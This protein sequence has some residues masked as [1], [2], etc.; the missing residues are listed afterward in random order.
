MKRFFIVM[1]LLAGGSAHAST[2]EQ[3]GFQV[4]RQICSSCHSLNYVTYSDLT[5]LGIS[6]PDIKSYASQHQVP[7]GLD[8]DGD[9]KTRPA[10]PSDHIGSPYPSESMARMA[11]HGGLPPDFSRLAL[12]QEGG[13]QRII[14]I[15]E[16]YTSAPAGT[17]LPPGAFYNTAM[18]HLHIAMPQP[19]HDGQVKYADGT[20]ATISQMANDVTAFLNW[21]ARPHR[22]ARHRTGIFVLAYLAGLAVLLG[23]LKHRVW[24]RLKSSEYFFRS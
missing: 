21:T 10:H 16:S 23:I 22:Q 4:F 9:P 19:L 7:D 20:T 15:L 2:P 5:G 24:K 18:P 1:L 17:T 11:N 8:E 12:I 13:P 6:V 14:H 3:R